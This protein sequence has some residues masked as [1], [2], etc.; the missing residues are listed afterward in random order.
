M[1]GAKK[2]RSEEHQIS[3]CPTNDPPHHPL[4]SNT[5]CFQAQSL[6][7]TVSAK[8]KKIKRGQNCQLLLAI[9]VR[10]PI[11]LFIVYFFGLSTDSLYQRLCLKA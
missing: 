2:L 9:Y 1:D 10:L 11:F 5:S 4:V 6:V 7:Q 3:L 8:A